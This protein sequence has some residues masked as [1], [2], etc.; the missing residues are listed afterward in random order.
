MEPQPTRSHAPGVVDRPVQQVAAEAL[1]DELGHQPEIGELD[2][3]RRAPIE[4]GIAGRHTADPQH[5]HL[6]PRV[7]EDG[8][9][10]GVA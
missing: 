4:L 7:A 2:V 6:D 9:E 10:F 5:V 3:R 8:L 1:A